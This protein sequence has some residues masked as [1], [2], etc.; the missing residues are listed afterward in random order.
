MKINIFPQPM[1]DTKHT[2]QYKTHKRKLW[3]VLRDKNLDSIRVQRAYCQKLRKGSARH[4]LSKWG[5]DDECLRGKSPV[6]RSSKQKVHH[7]V[8]LGRTLKQKVKRECWKSKTK[9]KKIVTH[10]NRKK[11]CIQTK[12]NKSHETFCGLMFNRVHLTRVCPCTIVLY[13]I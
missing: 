7:L 3:E 4:L 2:N 13:Y 5:I 11:K 10:V 12:K 9:R 6:S 8:L 1:A